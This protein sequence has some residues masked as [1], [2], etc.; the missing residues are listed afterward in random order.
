MTGTSRSAHEWREP[1]ETGDWRFLLPRDAAGGLLWIGP[2]GRE[3]P[4]DL[5]ESMQVT[6]LAGADESPGGDPCDLIAAV[7]PPES[8]IRAGRRWLARDLARLTT[9][10]RPGGQLYLEV[11]RPAAFVRP[12][13][14]R[15]LLEQFGYRDVRL[16]WPVR[17][18]ARPD[19]FLPLSDRRLQRYYIDRLLWRGSIVRRL[20][21]AVLR[22]LVRLGVF[23][24]AVPWYIAV[25]R[26]EHL[27]QADDAAAAGMLEAVRAAWPVLV[28]GGPPPTRIEWLMQP[29]GTARD[30]K[31]ICTTW[32]GDESAPAAVV[33]FSRTPH[34]DAGVHAEH[35][36][37]RLVRQHVGH[38]TIRVPRPLGWAV[39][40]GR[41]VAAETPVPGGP[42]V[43]Y[44]DE[45]PR[46]VATMAPLW[47]P[48]VEWLTD[49]HA[50]SSRPASRTDLEAL[51][52]D[53]MDHVV[54]ELAL[55]PVESDALHR[56]RDR[57]EELVARHPLAVVV[58]HHDLGP[59]NVFVSEAGRP[60]GVIDWESSG[61][62][63]PATDLLYFIGRLADAIASGRHPVRGWDFRTL[64][65][66][67]S[68]TASG[69]AARTARR[70][71]QVYCSRLGLSREWLPILFA[72][73]WIMHARNEG[74]KF[75][76]EAPRMYGQDGFFRRRLRVSLEE[77]DHLAFDGY[78]GLDPGAGG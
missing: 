22:I 33:K 50:R 76:A 53:P 61:P 4:R 78:L 16:Y 56:L 24:A 14:V 47:V 1:V 20:L 48:W 9:R 37:L 75:R 6:R 68:T 77:S 43:A 38:P 65:L 60:T 41:E 30:G 36:A 15:R 18:F 13:H 55:G 74:R 39:I 31:L 62:G 8:P 71:L 5:A 12:R 19:L 46:S 42:L 23:D 27:E 73:C 58:A 40:A 11:D 70:W 21:R 35:H 52:F 25:G 44:L 59:S 57:A 2:A 64:F 10:L 3:V 54:G 63:L 17:G 69:E 67:A 32:V 45:R 72:S 34:S 49:V 28:G 29:A 51:L 26:L 7:A 66:D